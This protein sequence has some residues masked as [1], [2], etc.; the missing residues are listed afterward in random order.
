MH[1][2]EWTRF[3][4]LLICLTKV[5]R[6]FFEQIMIQVLKYGISWINY[7]MKGC[8]CE[9]MKTFIKSAKMYLFW[10]HNFLGKYQKH[11]SI[12]SCIWPT[13]KNPNLTFSNISL[14]VN[15]NRSV[16]KD[17]FLLSFTQLCISSNRLFN[18]GLGPTTWLVVF[19]SHV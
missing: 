10:S 18:N 14:V 2:L 5:S 16:N 13:T 8:S 15:N 19:N 3:L 9:T 17:L 1:G 6:P 7:G 12:S 4:V 11:P